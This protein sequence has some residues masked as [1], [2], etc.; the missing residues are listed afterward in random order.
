MGRTEKR[1]FVVKFELREKV[2]KRWEGGN[3]MKIEINPCDL[4]K[5]L[6]RQN[7]NQSLQK[8]QMWY[9]QISCFCLEIAP[10]PL[11]FCPL[12]PPLKQNAKIKHTPGPRTCNLPHPFMHTLCSNPTIKRITG[13][14]YFGSSPS[15]FPTRL[16]VNR[17]LIHT[18]R[19]FRWDRT[20]ST[21][22]CN[23]SPYWVWHWTTRRL[24]YD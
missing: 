11:A 7:C 24:E 2:Y 5:S 9:V 15:P 6:K 19:R 8:K 22:H 12:F 13:K 14:N 1:T 21:Q 10:L 20:N 17:R 16:H 3:V 18:E 23:Y 4:C